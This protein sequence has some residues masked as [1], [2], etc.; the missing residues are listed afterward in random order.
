MS[1][2]KR[3][4]GGLLGADLSRVKAPSPPFDSDF[5]DVS[6]LFDG[7]S[8]TGSSMDLS[9]DARTFVVTGVV[10]PTTAVSSPYGGTTTDV[11]QFSGSS[12]KL[13]AS[14]NSLE[15]RD[16]DATNTSYEMWVYLPSLTSGQER[17]QSSSGHPY[18]LFSHSRDGAV[19]E[20]FTFG[21]AA[22]GSLAIYYWRGA[23]TYF[24]G[25]AGALT[26]NTWHHVAFVYDTSDNRLRGYVDGT[27]NL[28][29]A[30]VGTPTN[31]S[32]DKFMVGHGAKGHITGYIKDV[33][34]THGTARHVNTGGTYT[35][36]VPTSP[37][38]TISSAQPEIYQDP[39][40]VDRSTPNVGML[41]LGEAT[42]ESSPYVILGDWGSSPTDTRLVG[43]DTTSGDDFGHGVAISGDG[44]TVVVGADNAN[45]AYV[46]VD[47][48][49]VAVLTG[50]DSPSG[51]A[52]G[53]AVAISPDG[54]T[55]AVA[56]IL[57]D[58]SVNNSGAVYIYEKPESGWAT[59]TEDARL[60]HTDSLYINTYLGGNMAFSGDGSVLIAS[61][62]FSSSTGAVRGAVQIYERPGAFGTWANS[63]TF[64]RLTSSDLQTSDN[65]GSGVAISND[66]NTIAIGA[67]QEDTGG[68]NSGKVY[69]F[70]KP[71]GGWATGTEDH[72]IQG[73]NQ[74]AGRFF[75]ISCALNT[76]G[77]LLAV[78]A[79]GELFDGGTA[80]G[81]VHVLSFNGTSWSEDAVL[82]GLDV[83]S[84]DF[85]G[86]SMD[87]TPDGKFIVAS[88][89]LYDDAFSNQGCLYVWEKPSSGWANSSS[90]TRLLDSNV[91]E[92]ADQ[93]G[94]SNTTNSVV[95]I[96]DDGGKIIAGSKF[97]GTGGHA[98]LFD[99]GGTSTPR[100]LPILLWGGVRGRDS[101]DLGYT[102]GAKLA[103]KLEG[104]GIL[105][106]AEHYTRSRVPLT[107]NYTF[108]MWG[109][110][111]GGGGAYTNATTSTEH[112][113]PGGNGAYVSGTILGLASGTVLELLS[114]GAG[115]GG[116]G[117]SSSTAGTGGGAS[118]IRIQNGAI[119]VAAGGGA[120][121]GGSGGGMPN[122][123]TG[124]RGGNSIGGGN[125]Y[126]ANVTANGGRGGQSGSETTAGVGWTANASPPLKSGANHL[127]NGGDGQK[128][129]TS[130]V[131]D[132]TPATSH[133]ATWG[134]Q[135]GDSAMET[136]N[137]GPG[138]GGGGGYFGGAGGEG[139]GSGSDGGA[140]GGGG[141]SY[142][143]PSY[144]AG[145][146][147]E[148]G[149]FS[150]TTNHSGQAID[151]S[152]GSSATNHSSTVGKGGD[153]NLYTGTPA[154]SGGGDGQPGAVY[155]YD[156]DGNLVASVTTSAGTT[157]YT[158]P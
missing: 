23:E 153:G 93:L 104:T 131:G 90:P 145:V 148:E 25:T 51:D 149:S 58:S 105:G 128:K 125:P 135:G 76:D 57:W 111:G 30:R 95:Y 92:A 35:Y 124:G 60:N 120:G 107:P 65:F 141:G 24:D 66:G 16:W 85:V 75:G 18:P 126:A 103:A 96:S 5:D 73:S 143:H 113:G 8:V 109:A 68:G 147:S 150:N 86:Q 71:G 84:G 130:T 70:E 122:D 28:D 64:A 1:R 69:V 32:A 52:F 37:F 46:F 140:G 152:A 123:S 17:S 97:A 33:R 79:H 157:T 108:Q 13:E 45:K 110:G 134:G 116:D 14:T 89:H 99:N 62:R 41:S 38:P 7:S 72:I 56:A 20:Y 114:G 29:F 80:E 44:S 100:D 55:I 21:W 39:G 118:A 15:L 102:A 49:E 43:S 19:S 9:D 156:G 47:G 121:G 61:E 53:N 67:Y 112:S 42:I 83:S 132:G 127:Q 78:G 81:A 133:P 27:L 151:Q 119:L 59:A 146:A 117:G 144:V 11:L 98:V 40:S 136:S 12:S 63:T 10:N 155:I 154:T 82:R 87:M 34:I 50:S 74:H 94:N 129:G 36:P 2:S 26:A 22:N 101:F 91:Y 4:F 77:T 54:S 3:A 137:E 106:L 138:G 48:V 115:N 142:A 139:A 6:L 31:S 158:I 88:A